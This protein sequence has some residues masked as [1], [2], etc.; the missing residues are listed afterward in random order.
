MI[1]MARRDHR[2]L[3]F[4]VGSLTDLPYPDDQFAGVMLWYS[5]IHTPPAGQARIFAEATR[6][7]A[8]RRLPARRF[9]VRRRYARRVWGIPPV[10]ARDSPRAPPLHGGSRC[11][12][13]VGHPEV[14][15]RTFAP[16]VLNLVLTRSS[17]APR[18]VT[19]AAA[20]RW[21]TAYSAW[22]PA[23][24]DT[25]G[26]DDQLG[27]LHAVAHGAD[28]ASTFAAV[29]P[30]HRGAVLELCALRITAKDT[31]YRY[32]HL[33][34]ARLARA[35][36]AVLLTADLTLDQATG[37]L[38]IVEDAF[39]GAGPGPVPSWASNTFATLQALHLH[40]ARGLPKGVR[41]AMQRQSPRASRPSCAARTP[42]WPDRRCAS[43]G[44]DVYV[45][46]RPGPRVAAASR[47]E[48]VVLHHARGLN[49]H[50]LRGQRWP[51]EHCLPGDGPSPC[52]APTRRTAPGRERLRS[53]TA[54]RRG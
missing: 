13:E 27:W 15:A 28:V 31:D 37:W 26:W 2:D 38:A 16:L 9:P 3:A 52:R 7:L 49:W 8:P 21:Y 14:Q 20:E 50:R 11:F 5:I 53:T 46:R 25:R 47:T 34:D 40:L 41:R 19:E 44:A 18:L 45:H 1:A 10:R 54:R 48:T 24:R 36:T 33:E 23:E 39:V 29:L 42:G 32:A 22:Y 6:V 12:P 4:T 35:V 30:Q 43:A 17:R 51:P